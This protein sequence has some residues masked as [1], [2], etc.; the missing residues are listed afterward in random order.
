MKFDIQPYYGDKKC[1]GFYVWNKPTFFVN[2]D[3]ERY[4]S[5]IQEK[6]ETG[7]SH[8]ET[9]D[10]KTNIALFLVPRLKLFKKEQMGV[11]G[12]PG[13]FET[14]EEWYSVL[15][16]MIFAFEAEFK[17]EFYIPD[18]YIKKYMNDEY[19]T[20]GR[21]KAEDAYWNDIQEGRNLFSEYFGCLWW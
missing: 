2:K 7:M 5:M 21:K 11:G 4:D 10:L 18:V 19:D 13:C 14:K 6:K 1:K 20:D 9:W 16:K 3:D 8:D 12:H 15:D 17:D